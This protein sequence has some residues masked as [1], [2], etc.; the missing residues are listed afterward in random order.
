MLDSITGFHIEPTNICM[1]KCPRCS[2]TQ[3][4]EQF[5][6]QKWDNKEIDL[7]SFKK[8]F[9]IDLTGKRFDLRGNDGDPIYYSNL[10]P[11]VEWIKA[12]GATVSI[13]TN[14]SYKKEPFWHELAGLLTDEDILTFAVDGSP[15]NFTQYRIN[16]NWQSIELAMKIMSASQALT[17]W[18]Y[19]PFSFN[20][21]TID[22]SRELSQLLGIKQ[23]YLDPSDRWLG[24]DDP[25]HP[26]KATGR[27]ETAIIEWRKD[28]AKIEI[29]P[30]CKTKYNHHYISA[31]GYYMPCPFVGDFRFYYKSEFY[32]NRE[33]YD[34]SKTTITQVL[35]TTQN[36][37]NTL[38]ESKRDYCTFNC[39]KL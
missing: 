2:R 21:N 17:K 15:D 26:K 30:A 1:L 10:L 4:I 23:F 33:Q 6:I 29:D 36:F 12:Q 11:M 7:E 22:E 31:A 16:A 20:E 39:P 34:I 19:I 18:K 35:N 3:F 8:F 14:G 38:E 5:G 9:D 37:Y 25:L 13:T 27:R 32:K 28:T 24:N